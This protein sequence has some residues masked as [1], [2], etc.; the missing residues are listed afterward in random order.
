MCPHL[1]T[2]TAH[3]PQSERGREFEETKKQLEEDADREIEELKEKYEAKLTQEREIG[4]RLKGTQPLR[5][6]DR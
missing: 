4:L 1:T 6:P 5:V 2:V 3:T